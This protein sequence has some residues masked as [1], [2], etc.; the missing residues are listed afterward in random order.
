M[1]L[2]DQDISNHQGVSYRTPDK[3]DLNTRRI[4]EKLL[5]FVLP[6]APIV[7]SFCGDFDSDA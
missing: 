1:L 3:D 6:N 4:D 2:F 7:Q 5:G